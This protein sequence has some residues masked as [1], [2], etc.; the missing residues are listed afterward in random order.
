MPKNSIKKT[1][2][3]MAILM[4]ILLIFLILPA[5]VIFQIYIRH[6]SQKENSAEV[7]SQFEQLIARNEGNIEQEK[8][9]FSQKCIQAAE[10]AAYFVQ[11]HPTVVFNLESMRELAEK[12]EVDEL[13]FFTKEGELYTGT[14]PQYYGLTFHS[15]SQMEYFLPILE[16]RSLK[17]CQEITP[18]TAEG[19]E[20]QY[21][22]VWIADGSDI[23]QIGMEPERVLQEINDN[24][25]DKIL[26]AIPMDMEGYF[27]VVDANTG[28]VVAS[29]SENVMGLDLSGEMDHFPS[30]NEMV[31]FHSRFNGDRFCVYLKPFENYLLVRCYRSSRL[32]V[33]SIKSTAM[34]FLYI[35]VVAIVVISM[36][37]WYV[38]KK[39]SRNVTSIVNNLKKIKQGNM[40]NLELDTGI[41]EFDELIFYVNQLLK[42]IRLNWEKLSGVIEKGRIPI[43][44]Y[45][46][47]AF[48]KKQFVNAR[49]LELLG[50]SQDRGATEYQLACMVKER[51]IQA[52]RNCVN[53]KEQIYAYDKNGELIYLRIEK[54]VDEQSETCYVTDVSLWWKEI[55]ELREQSSRDSLTGLLN[56]R[57]LS[58][59]LNDLF[60]NPQQI[61]YGA[62]VM[63]DAD[64]LKRINDIYGHHMGDEYL[65]KIGSL[66]KEISDRRGVCARLGG[67]EF[68]IFLYGLS[69]TL[70]V[71][72]IIDRLSLHRGETFLTEKEEVRV[73]LEFSMGYAFYPMDGQDYHTL[74]HI[75]D[76]NMYQEKKRRKN[77]ESYLR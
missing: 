70:E 13:H 54:D 39:L 60:R 7:L 47:N 28:E 16:D 44:I 56:R 11:Y 42:S 53:E 55:N 61:G 17:L 6:E 74:M 76:E 21:A 73:T 38:N 22:A 36:I 19:K 33:D 27:H 29:T 30:G 50:I 59:R 67:D 43:G 64:G 1:L 20:M 75:A 3:R 69:G 65:N 12:L 14:H 23:I 46:N 37:V 24:S 4:I 35:A 32:I 68:V 2:P 25:L 31:W 15:G 5:N 8:E 57:G 48:Y 71:E 72:E 40:E 51:L 77:S 63:V 52:Q 18:N 41:Y 10:M 62:M 9:D 58:D 66:L 49:M 34:V 45:E 26:S